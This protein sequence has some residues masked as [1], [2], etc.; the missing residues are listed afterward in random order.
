MFWLHLNNYMALVWKRSSCW[1]RG[2][3]E[4]H[5]VNTRSHRRQFCQFFK[6][7]S[8]QDSRCVWLMDSNCA[9]FDIWWVIIGPLFLIVNWGCCCCCVSGDDLIHHGVPDCDRPCLNSFSLVSVL[10][11]PTTEP[12]ESLHPL[13]VFLALS[14]SWIYLFFLVM[15]LFCL[16]KYF[17]R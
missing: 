9:G 2:T 10:M 3:F 16:S 5:R 14:R 15:K 7:A 13:E 1:A 17:S 12:C 8:G 11:K 6:D 4:L